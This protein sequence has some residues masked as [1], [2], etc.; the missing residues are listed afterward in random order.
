MFRYDSNSGGA[1]GGGFATMRYARDANHGWDGQDVLLVDFNRAVDTR[2]SSVGANVI[3]HVSNCIGEMDNG[4][5]KGGEWGFNYDYH[6]MANVIIDLARMTPQQHQNGNSSRKHGQQ[7]ATST[8]LNFE[9]VSG[10]AVDRLR[11]T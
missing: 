11:S 8:G 1:Q 7:Q 9:S 5:G 2:H 10:E 3:A 6:S 4:Y